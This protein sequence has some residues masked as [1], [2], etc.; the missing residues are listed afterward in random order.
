MTP[1]APNGGGASWRRRGSGRDATVIG[2]AVAVAFHATILAWIA[3]VGVGSWLGDDASLDDETAAAAIDPVVRKPLDPSC[4]A[5][6]VLRAAAGA[7]WCATP[8]VDDADDCLD[9]VDAR[10][11]TDFIQCHI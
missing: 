10:L 9:L 5:D 4:D 3:V 1:H 7:A 8:F 11:R 2:V 6:A